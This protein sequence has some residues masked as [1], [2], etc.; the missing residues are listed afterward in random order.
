MP[1]G[2]SQSGA[3]F[4]LRRRGQGFSSDTAN[5]PYGVEKLSHIFYMEMETVANI[6]NSDL[7]CSAPDL[8]HRLDDMSEAIIREEPPT[9]QPTLEGLTRYPYLRQ[10]NTNMAAYVEVF[11]DDFLGLAQEPS[12]WGHQVQ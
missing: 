2:C 9:L 3:I 11:V 4:F 8:P 7:C 12:Y 5:P 10:S 1:N 6:V